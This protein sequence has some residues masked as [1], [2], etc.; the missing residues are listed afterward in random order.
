M[1]GREFVAVFWLLISVIIILGLAYWVT[2]RVARVAS[3]GGYPIGAK[4]QRMKVLARL[5]LGKEGTLVMVQV[6]D[7]YFL[8][9]V[10]AGRISSLAEFTEEEVEIW[11]HPTADA[12][13]KNKVPCFQGMLRKMLRQKDGGREP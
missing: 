7:R 13:E 5:P 10:T 11:L 3:I 4:D 2:R 12:D 8:L 6:N 1:F 9:G